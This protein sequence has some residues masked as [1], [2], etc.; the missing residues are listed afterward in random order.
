M[1]DE[2][3]KCICA[4]CGKKLQDPKDNP[5]YVAPLD[6]YFCDGTCWDKFREFKDDE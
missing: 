4:Q 2:Q 1:K 6:L 3:H 5:I